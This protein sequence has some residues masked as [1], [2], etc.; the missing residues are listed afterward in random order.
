MI[1][2][3]LTPNLSRL[4]EAMPIVSVTVPRQP[5]K[6]TLCRSTF[7]SCSTFRW[8][9][10]TSGT[11]LVDASERGRFPFPERISLRAVAVQTF[12]LVL[13]RFATSFPERFAAPGSSPTMTEHPTI[14]RM[15]PAM[16]MA[17]GS[18]AYEASTQISAGLSFVLVRPTRLRPC[19]R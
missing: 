1:A 17:I 7:P 9:R 5:G 13:L 15:M 18:L 11:A 10:P 2:R 14:L 6:T 19:A 3:N 16:Q 4:A 12:L 8:N